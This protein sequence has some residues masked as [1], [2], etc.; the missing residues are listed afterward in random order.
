MSQAAEKVMIRNRFSLE[1]VGGTY[2]SCPW[3]LL[4]QS[5]SL[6]PGLQQA[7][8]KGGQGEQLAG[9]LWIDT[10]VLVCTSSAL[11]GQLLLLALSQAKGLL[12]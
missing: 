11:P 10:Q 12:E 6:A 3:P 7:P 5:P 9:Q 2:S 8:Q 4:I 1:M